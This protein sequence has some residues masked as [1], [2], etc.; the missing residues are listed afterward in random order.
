MSSTLYPTNSTAWEASIRCRNE[1][2]GEFHCMY[3][4][5]KSLSVITSRSGLCPIEP[6]RW[7]TP[8]KSSSPGK[9][10]AS[11]TVSGSEE[12]LRQMPVV[13]RRHNA[14]RPSRLRQSHDR[15]MDA[16]GLH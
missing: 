10:G 9:S 5:A 1:K 2:V 6:C 3:E 15:P 13:V 14:S 16:I 11:Y 4:R 12:Q 7:T 8:V